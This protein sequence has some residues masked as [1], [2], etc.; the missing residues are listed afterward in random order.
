MD[1]FTKL[2]QQ[3]SEVGTTLV[4]ILQ[5]QEARPGEAEYL[6]QRHTG[7]FTLIPTAMFG[8][9]VILRS[10]YCKMNVCHSLD[11]AQTR[12][13]IA[14]LA[15]TWKVLVIQFDFIFLSHRALAILIWLRNHWEYGRLLPR[16]LLST[17]HVEAQVLYLSPVT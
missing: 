16:L 1:P 4:V 10:S 15:S 14:C 5:I 17:P 2:P 6:A 7:L 13:S 3:P 11:K 12:M 8:R 9:H